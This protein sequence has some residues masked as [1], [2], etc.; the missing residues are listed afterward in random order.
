MADTP[1]PPRLIA[2]AARLTAAAAKTT[3]VT[4]NAARTLLAEQGREKTLGQLVIVFKDYPTISL[5]GLYADA[6][7]RIVEAED[8]AAGE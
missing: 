5:A 2:A 3:P 4:I 6:V 1:L 7:L 8:A